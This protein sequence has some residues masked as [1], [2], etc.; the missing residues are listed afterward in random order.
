MSLLLIFA[1]QIFL[2][3]I[4][5]LPVRLVVGIFLFA[6]T[7]LLCLVITA[8]WNPPDQLRTP[9]TPWRRLADSL[10]VIHFVNFNT[11]GKEL[12][13]AHVVVLAYNE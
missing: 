12:P 8:G 2:G 4:F 7:G 5:L 10:K 13:M 9:L 1:F 11:S 3:L 6:F